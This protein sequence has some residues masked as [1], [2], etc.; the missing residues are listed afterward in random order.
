MHTLEGD[1]PMKTRAT[2]MAAF[3]LLAATSTASAAMDAD[4][5][6]FA[7]NWSCVLKSGGATYSNT[8]ANSVWGS[9]I[10]EDLSFPAQMGQP[11]SV[12][13]AYL[14]YDAQA[15]L[16]IYDEIDS[17]G[18][19]FIN[20]SDSPKLRDSSW[21]SAFPTGNTSTIHI[22]SPSQYTVDGSYVEDGKTSSFHQVCTRK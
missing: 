6:S 5:Q 21:T 7:G 2:I 20:K 22:V 13:T 9:W 15:H 19:H 1:L 3:L 18:E 14:G 12:G 8:A 17:V 16:W 11:A 10:K 4:L